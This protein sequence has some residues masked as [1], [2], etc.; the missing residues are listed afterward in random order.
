MFL[1]ILAGCSKQ[2][3]RVAKQQTLSEKK[4]QV[5]TVKK[6]QMSAEKKRSSGEED[7][8]AKVFAKTKYK[9]PLKQTEK[10]EDTYPVPYQIDPIGKSCFNNSDF[11]KNQP[12]FGTLASKLRQ[13]HQYSW[14]P[15]WHYSGKGEVLIPS[16]GL[17]SDK[18]IFCILETIPVGENKKTSLL[19]FINTY[20]WQI[21]RIFYFKQYNFIKL[22]FPTKG[23]NIILWHSPLDGTDNKYGISVINIDSGKE[24]VKYSDFNSPLES[25]GYL[26]KKKQILL[27]LQNDTALYILDYPKLNNLKKLDLKLKQSKLIINNNQIAIINDEKITLLSSDLKNLISAWDNLSHSIPDNFVFLGKNSSFF[28]FSSF[29]KKTI[30][31]IKGK[32]KIL[33]EISGKV[34]NYRKDNNSL[35]FEEMK[36]NQIH[37]LNLSDFS[38][39]KE[40]IPTKIH[41]KTFAGAYFMSYMPGI[42]KYLILDKQATL[43]L[44]NQQGKKWVKQIIFSAAKK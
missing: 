5:L 43:C 4:N 15:K 10:A 20:T 37:F 38:E 34:L 30:L 29:M 27:K 33:T 26:K 36:N 42:K 3:K 22:L 35:A 24:L 41:P 13:K 39:S 23:K 2:E 40:L 1:L 9:N 12:P 16:V 14:Q 19:V 25:W 28:A 32:N 8:F 44:Y 7:S 6:E 17:S 18:S 11:A 21:S 31:H